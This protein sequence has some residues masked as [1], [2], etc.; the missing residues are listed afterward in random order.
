MKR[1]GRPLARRF[2][3][4]MATQYV[5]GLKKSRAASY[6]LFFNN[7]KMLH[8]NSAYPLPACNKNSVTSRLDAEIERKPQGG[9]CPAVP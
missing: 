6:F 2:P 4:L 1:Q 8:K 7:I 3:A 9:N 5:S